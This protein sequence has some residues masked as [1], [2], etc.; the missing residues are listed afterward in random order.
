MLRLLFA[1]AAIGLVVG[2]AAGFLGALHP[3]F[4]TIAHFR[5][6]FALGLLALTV[7]GLLLKIRRAPFILLLFALLG[8]WGSDAGNRIGATAIAAADDAAGRTL[9]H[10]NLRFD[11]PRRDDVIAM[12]R[13]QNPDIITVNEAS[14]QWTAHLDRLAETWPHRFH[15]PEWQAIGGTMILSKFPLRSDRDYCHAYAAVGL[16]EV[17]IGGHWIELGVAHMRWPWPASGPRQL[18]EMTPRLQQV[19][20]DALIAGDFNAATW[21]HAVKEFARRS[22]SSVSTGFGGTWMYKHLPSALAPRLGLPIDNVLAKGRVEVLSVESLPPVG[23]DHLPLL[24]KFE[25]ND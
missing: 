22:G 1:L 3:A 24:V 16:T 19:G 17:L 14:R 13:A 20:G 4:D 5:W 18:R 25:V 8:V 21:S 7:I 2:M 10:F 9:L 12:F 15:C 23:S 6:H 11:N